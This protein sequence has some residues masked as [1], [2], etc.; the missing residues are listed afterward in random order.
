MGIITVEAKD[1]FAYKNQKQCN[2]LKVKNCSGCSF[3]KTKEQFQS[4]K[5][6]ALEIILSLDQKTQDRI[7]NK[8]YGGMGCG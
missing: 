4:D 8:Y 3:Y 7:N 6:K 2:A 5:Q 1:C